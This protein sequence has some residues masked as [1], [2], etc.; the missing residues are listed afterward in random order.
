[1][2]PFHEADRKTLV[3][4]YFVLAIFEPHWSGADK[5]SQEHET[6]SIQSTL[7]VKPFIFSIDLDNNMKVWVLS[8]QLECP[9]IS[10][11][12]QNSQMIYNRLYFK[13]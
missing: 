3:S 1:M 11:S 8:Y 9:I 10:L 7:E 12:V 13:A 6:S 2:S 5:L 4:V